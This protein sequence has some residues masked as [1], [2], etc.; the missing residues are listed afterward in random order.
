MATYYLPSESGWLEDHGSPC[1]L[2]LKIE[3]SY[4]GAT[5]KSTLTVTPQARSEYVGV[6]FMLL[7]NAVL[8]A[9]GVTLLAA[10]SQAGTGDSGYRFQGTENGWASMTTTG[11]TVKSFSTSVTHN[12][13]GAASVAALMHGRLINADWGVN[14]AFTD[15]ESA[16]LHL[17]N[18]RNYTLT[19]SAG[20]GTGVTVKRGGTALS[21]G[22]TVSYG[23]QLAVTFAAVS[24]YTLVS[25]TVNGASFTSGGTHTVAGAVTVSATAT[26]NA[27]TIASASSSA[28]TQGS[29]ALSMNRAGVNYHKATVTAG[30]A[31]LATTAAFVS[32]VSIPVPRSWFSGYPSATSFT[33]TLTV[34]SYTT[35]ACTE[36][37]GAAVMRSV[38]IKADSG[39]AP[40]LQTGYATASAYNTGA[41]SGLSGY[42]SGYSK[43]TVTL[44]AAKLDMSAAAGAT[45][46]GISVKGGGQTA[47]ASPY[48]TGVLTGTASIT[49]TVTDSRGRQGT[50]TLSVSTLDYAPPKLSGVTVFRC[51]SGGTADEDGAWVS[52][53]ATASCSSLNGQNSVTLA[54]NGTA[55]T[56]GTA[57]ILSAG[58]A[59]DTVTVTVTATDALGNT[60][61]AQR[62]VP[63]RKWAMR[64][65]ETGNSVGFGTSPTHDAAVNLREGWDLFFGNSS[66]ADKVLA[67]MLL[68][69]TAIPE[70]SDLNDYTTPGSFYVPNSTV[71]AT[72]SNMPRVTVGGRLWVLQGNSLSPEA[73]LQIYLVTGSMVTTLH[74]RRYY[75]GSWGRWYEMIIDYTSGGTKTGGGVTAKWAL[76]GR[77]AFVSLS[78]SLSSAKAADAQILSGLPKAVY[79]AWITLPGG[80]SAYV[81]DSGALCAGEALSSGQSVKGSVSYLTALE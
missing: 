56:S 1:H 4:D 60:A 67:T 41:A 3:Q 58:S 63:G 68:R 51:N 21:N 37:V 64:F 79:T 52:V 54:A 5:N 66:F 73:F 62:T 25:H 31:T 74:L 65:G 12:A 47:T 81:N 16:T 42:I 10:Q 80:K 75:N 18:T 22:A 55:L 30:G 27:S 34:R 76:N 29:I 28:T 24:G 59:D 19:I 7:D 13:S 49:V 50:Q 72:L 43:A 69:G 26:R 35:S 11:G 77:S 48:R 33:A 57:K 8:T 6:T 9:G 14:L 70:N 46:S 78:G 38:T 71:A 40:V 44:N 36:S 45:V 20:T 23:E 32:S 17:Q 15:N 39:M 53:K 61:Q 2:R